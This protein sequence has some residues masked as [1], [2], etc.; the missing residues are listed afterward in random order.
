MAKKGF[1]YKRLL[2][3]KSLIMNLKSM[4]LR[5]SED[6]HRSHNEKLGKIRAQKQE[7]LNVDSASSDSQEEAMSSRDLQVHT[8]YTEQLN[9]DLRRQVH[10][11]R[12]AEEEMRERRK[13][14]E[15]SA[16]EKQSL[17][18]LK[19]HQD[20]ATLKES[21]REEQKQLDEIASRQH[22]RN[23]DRKQS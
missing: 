8:W 1:Q 22:S 21:E 11:V 16:K 15:K 3:V 4:A 7:H 23:G 2:D 12:I 17:E 14:V 18:K 5:E 19:E 10:E 13:V 9:E 20:L 6:K